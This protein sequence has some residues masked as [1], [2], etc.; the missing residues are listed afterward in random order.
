M[1]LFDLI[2]SIDLCE[3][4][5]LAQ[6]EFSKTSDVETVQAELERFKKLQ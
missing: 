5:Q 1:R 6:K 3:N 4:F 2:E